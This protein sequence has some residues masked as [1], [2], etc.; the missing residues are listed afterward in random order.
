MLSTGH[1][2]NLGFGFHRNLLGS[3]G[4]DRNLLG[5][6]GFGRNLFGSF[7]FDRNLL[8]KFCFCGYFLRCFSLSHFINSIL[9]NR[10]NYFDFFCFLLVCINLS[11]LITLTITIHF[12]CHRLRDHIPILRLL[13]LTIHILTIFVLTL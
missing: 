5:G 6:F 10:L 1:I 11:P 12:L 8:S 9:L 7:S 4:F 2:F 3:F 13:C